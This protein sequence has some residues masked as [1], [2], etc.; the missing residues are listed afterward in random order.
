MLHAEL[1]RQGGVY[2]PMDSDPVAEASYQVDVTP[3]VPK[4]APPRPIIMDPA[5]FASSSAPPRLQITS[6]VRNTDQDPPLGTIRSLAPP[7]STLPMTSPL[8]ERMPPP[9]EAGGLVPQSATPPPSE[10]QPSTATTAPAVQD[11]ASSIFYDI[12]KPTCSLNLVCYRSG[13]KGCDLQ[14]IQCVLRTMFPSDE[15]FDTVIEANPHLIYSDNQFFEE[16]HRLYRT[17]MCGFFRRYF[18]LK[19]LRAFRV[20]A[21]R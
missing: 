21:V 18:S 16:M 1:V 14:Q 20:L 9:P 11:A 4:Q 2:V 6:A 12:S 17:R 19:T 7:V 8:V 10:K 13:A 5:I 3:P 15:S